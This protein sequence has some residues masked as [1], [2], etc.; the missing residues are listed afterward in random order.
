MEKYEAVQRLNDFINRDAR[1]DEERQ[2]LHDCLSK[3]EQNDT[4]DS[5]KPLLKNNEFN[6]FEKAMRI[7]KLR[8]IKEELISVYE[9]SGVTELIR[10][11]REL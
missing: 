10:I 6:S 5:I 2:Y 4:Y 9:E 8:E 11:L 3:L 7:V 1:S